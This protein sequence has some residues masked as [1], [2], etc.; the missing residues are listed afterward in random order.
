MCVPFLISIFTDAGAG[1]LLGEG[2]GVSVGIGVLVGSSA[3]GVADTW[4][5]EAGDADNSLYTTTPSALAIIRMTITQIIHF[6][7]ARR[8]FEIMD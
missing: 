4:G 6:F 3:R 7:C 1:V 8:L 5:A 2:A